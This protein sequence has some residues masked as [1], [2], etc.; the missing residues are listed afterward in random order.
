MSNITNKLSTKKYRNV[1][2][3]KIMKFSSFAVSS[4]RVGGSW[5]SHV[6]LGMGRGTTG[7]PAALPVPNEVNHVQAAVCL[8]PLLTCPRRVTET[9]LYC[10]CVRRTIIATI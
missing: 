5:H 3:M 10:D 1:L 6:T 8:P 4:V 9:H 7:L 2:R